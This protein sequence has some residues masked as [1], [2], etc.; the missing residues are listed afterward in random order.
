[1]TI[2]L[3]WIFLDQFQADGDVVEDY[4]IIK[5][6]W[7]SLT[8]CS[9]TRSLLIRLLAQEKCDFFFSLVED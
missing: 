5:I 4:A 3:I 6:L 1:M 9:S 2:P 7:N 8:R